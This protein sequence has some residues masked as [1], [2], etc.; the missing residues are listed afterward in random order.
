MALDWT[1]M[2]WLRLQKAEATKAKIDTW[3]S[4]KLESSP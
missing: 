4:I 3:D 1:K 2:L